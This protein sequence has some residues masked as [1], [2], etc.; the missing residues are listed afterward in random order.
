M[1]AALA[2]SRSAGGSPRPAPRVDVRITKVFCP[3]FPPDRSASD[4]TDWLK[5]AGTNDD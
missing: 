2:S 4:V 1:E 5:K 3:V